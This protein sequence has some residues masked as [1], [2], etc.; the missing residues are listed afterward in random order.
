MSGLDILRM[1]VQVAVA[2]FTLVVMV[3]FIAAGVDYPQAFAVFT[4]SVNGELFVEGGVRWGG[5]KL[6]HRREQ[7]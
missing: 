6:K 7:G 3:V 4:W 1:R 2:V 5:R